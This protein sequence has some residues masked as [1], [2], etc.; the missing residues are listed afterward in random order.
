MGDVIQFPRPMP[1]LE[2]EPDEPEFVDTLGLSAEV[3]RAVEVTLALIA[4]ETARRERP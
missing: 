1:E 2:P 4:E 3:V